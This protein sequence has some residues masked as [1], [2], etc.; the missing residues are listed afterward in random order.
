MPRSSLI[1]GYALVA[2]VVVL[3]LSGILGW[4]A[5][6]SSVAASQAI[7]RNKD[8]LLSLDR[9]L[10]AVR[11]AE[12]GQRGYL[13]TGRDSY[14]QPYNGAVADLP[15]RL[16]QLRASVSSD[17]A[18]A[19]QVE[20]LQAAIA[21]KMEEL[22]RTVQLQQSRGHDDAMAE[23]LTDRG[24]QLM[25]AVVERSTLLQAQQQKLFES[26]IQ[27]L[28]A[29]R[30]WVA[31]SVF[32][33][34]FLTIA[35][36]I[37]LVL[38]VRRETRQLRLSEERLAIT[39]RSI[40]DAVIATD[41]EGRVVLLNTVAEELTG[42]SSVRARGA[43]LERVFRIV[44]EKHREPVESPVA[45][46]VREGRV[47][48]VGNHTLLLRRGGGEVPIEDSAAPIRDNSGTIIGVVLVFRD[49][50]SERQIARQL[51]EADQKKDEFI[52]VLAHELRNP[53]APILQAVQ[54]SRRPAATAEQRQWSLDVIERQGRAMG[55]LLDDLL[56][57]SRIT[58]GTVDVNKS[59]VLLSEVVDS[60]VEISRPL[61]Q[62]RRHSLVLDVPEQTVTIEADPLRISQVVANLLTN[63]AKYTNPGG[64]LRL[65]ASVM[66]SE[67]TLSVA[68]NGI[69]I[70][71]MALPRVF[72]MFVQVKGPLDR[73]EGGLGIGLA[74]SKK[75]VELHGGTV[76]ARSAGPDQG[77]EFIVR[78]PCVV[79]NAQ[80]PAA[81]P[82][83]SPAMKRAR[84]R[85]VVADDNR[86][87]ADSLAMLLRLDGHEVGVAHDGVTALELIKQSKP[88]VAVLDI[89]M[90]GLNGYQVAEQARANPAT[91]RILLVALTGWGQAQDLERANAAGF[92]HHLV[93]PAEPNAVRALMQTQSSD[94]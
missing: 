49:A 9:T 29:A 54:I 84:L 61:I 81:S 72:D 5:A 37:T 62:E 22:A 31:V 25:D 23:V 42:W 45:R 88:Q 12:S 34:R 13:L 63:A 43:P 60:A 40:G 83:R 21:A 17:A 85:V 50:T 89:G 32:A 59:H 26:E 53:L 66:Q 93:K 39:L 69:G 36:L 86:D 70:D 82:E 20:Q 33:V 2:A 15:S 77:S 75:L 30:V 7:A 27:Q 16:S 24:A 73:Q 28:S 71:P 1:V 94:S 90:P 35:L 87:A 79:E 92:D 55:H 44:D 56:D 46:V 41:A 10:S 3:V 58:R 52:A 67:L 68:D 76:E 74:V 38:V 78:M 91:A 47:I 48:G 4:R 11:E 65:K 8:T 64:T 18:T 19:R 6:Q 14:L 51:L 57:V 80:S